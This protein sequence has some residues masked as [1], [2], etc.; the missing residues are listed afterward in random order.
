[1]EQKLRRLEGIVGRMGSVAVALSG[2]VD[3]GLVAKVAR[4]CLGDAAI[5]LT[6]VSPSLAAQ[7]RQAVAELVRRI[8]IR[9]RYLDS[10]ETEDP[11][12][13]ANAPDRCY[14]CKTNVYEVLIDYAE[15]EGYR[16]VVDGTNADDAGDHRP[17]RRA[18]RERGVRSPLQEAAVTKAEVRAMAKDLGL[19]IWD[20]PAA[21]CLASRIPYGSAVTHEKLSQV[22]AAEARLGALGLGQLRVRHHGRIARLEVEPR[23]LA[24]VLERRQRIARELKDLGFVYVTL[25][26]EGFR[27]GS[28]NE[29]L[30]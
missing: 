4:D 8:G 24:L 27:S 15:G 17:G 14:F 5:A 30:S 7:E 22:E 28:M 6:A 2:G 1:M 12:Y 10:H 20:K 29:V 21:A 13:R 18:A 25:D 19:S 3:S 23:E 16:C 11:R 9:H 26:L